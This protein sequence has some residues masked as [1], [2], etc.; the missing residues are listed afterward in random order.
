VNYDKNPSLLAMVGLVA[1]VV[2]IVIL[3]FVA[4]GYAF[5]RYFL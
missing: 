4:I 3:V 5:G 1:V 2:I